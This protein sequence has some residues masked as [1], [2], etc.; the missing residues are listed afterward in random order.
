MRRRREPALSAAEGYELC[1]MCGQPVTVGPDGRCELGHRVRTPVADVW[2]DDDP[3]FADEAATTMPIA[4][5]DLDEP[6]PEGE[7]R[8]ALAGPL[9][10]DLDADDE[11][12]V[13]TAEPAPEEPDDG[14]AASAGDEDDGAEDEP[15]EPSRP[16]TD[17]GGELDW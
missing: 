1:P 2:V 13:A 8:E 6:L 16:A 14:E 4:A 9:D 15:A 7:L 12:D 5:V 17:L 10:L 11:D 3:T